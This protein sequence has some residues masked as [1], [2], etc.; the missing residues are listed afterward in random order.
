[1]LIGSQLCCINM[2][3]KLCLQWNDFQENIKS[4]FWSFREDN[5]FA[6]VTLAREDG[7]QLEAHKLILAGQ[8]LLDIILQSSSHKH[9]QHQH[10]QCL[11]DLLGSNFSLVNCSVSIHIGVSIQYGAF[12][13]GFS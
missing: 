4:A 1:M 7:Q 3:E 8:V 9:Q 12:I 10:Q 5:D 6:D 2:S 11:I 13:D